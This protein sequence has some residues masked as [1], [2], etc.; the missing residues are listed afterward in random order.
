VVEQEVRGGLLT[1]RSVKD[2]YG[3]PGLDH[4]SL[5]DDAPLVGCEVS[6]KV[7]DVVGRM[8]D[9]VCWTR[10]FL[11][12][13]DDGLCAHPG[14]DRDIDLPKRLEPVGDNPRYVG[15]APAIR[16]SLGRDPLDSM[17][18]V[19]MVRTDIDDDLAWRAH[20]ADEVEA[21]SASS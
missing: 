10:G 15:S 7:R 21:C 9:Q 17:R 3:A 16:L 20:L 6:S 1:V 11:K 2:H 19:P 12:N 13:F 8:Q 5:L 4:E 18:N 14:D